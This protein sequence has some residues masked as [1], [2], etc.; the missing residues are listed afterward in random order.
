MLH[1]SYT[2]NEVSNRDELASSMLQHERLE[3][4]RACQG[5]TKC[6]SCGLEHVNLLRNADEIRRVRP[7]GLSLVIHLLR[8]SLVRKDGS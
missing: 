6:S 3:I 5:K 4:T 7:G 8:I 2:Y 1:C